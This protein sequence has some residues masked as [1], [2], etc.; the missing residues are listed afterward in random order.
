MRVLVVSESPHE[1]TSIARYLVERAHT[2]ETAASG[3]AALRHLERGTPEIVILGWTVSK[4]ATVEV[5]RRLRSVEGV[6]HIY[7]IVVMSDPVASTVSAA[8]AAGADDLLR[9]PF[10][11]EELVARVGAIERIRQWAAKVLGQVEDPTSKL[12]RLQLG[13][14][15]EGAIREDLGSLFQRPLEVRPES[16]LEG[17][18]VVAVEIPIT[19][20]SEGIEY[21]LQIGLD[22]ASLEATAR[23]LLGSDAEPADAVVDMLRELANVTAGALVGAAESD[24]VSATLGLPRNAGLVS[25]WERAPG[26]AHEITLCIPETP[27]ELSIRLLVTSRELRSLPANELRPGMVLA[28][29]VTNGEGGMLMPAATLL[30][31]SSVSRLMKVLGGGSTVV[32]LAQ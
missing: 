15:G 4:P 29:D 30:T 28:R 2:V 22:A 25:T 26:T 32:V 5:I 13:R 8:F 16:S 17:R 1:L 20:V 11:R 10:L 14:A 3:S 23:V 9:R 12:A 19:L 27:I 24:G 6:R 18:R 31:E 7:S 21:C